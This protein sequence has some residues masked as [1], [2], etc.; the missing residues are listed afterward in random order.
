LAAAFL[1]DVAIRPPAGQ[2]LFIVIAIAGN[3]SNT[4]MKSVPGFF[5]RHQ[6]TVFRKP[7]SKRNQA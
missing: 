7:V 1:N 6:M 3:P 4:A 2:R 5:L